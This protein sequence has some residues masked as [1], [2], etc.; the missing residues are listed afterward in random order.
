M[1]TTALNIDLHGSSQHIF[2][3]IRTSSIFLYILGTLHL[4]NNMRHIDSVHTIPEINNSRSELKP[5]IGKLIVDIIAESLV[6][7]FIALVIW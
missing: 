4:A 6:T 5:H 7:Q 3:T 1:S 2:S